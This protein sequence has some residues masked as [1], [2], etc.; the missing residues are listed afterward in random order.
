[1]EEEFEMPE[2]LS[3]EMKAM[4]EAVLAVHFQEI[5]KEPEIGT[6]Y[7]ISPRGCVTSTGTKWHGCGR[8][9]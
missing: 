1:M 6:W 4:M 2:G 8:L 7:R 3:E 5:P 9:K